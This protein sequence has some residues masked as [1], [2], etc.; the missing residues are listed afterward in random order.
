[1]DWGFLGGSL[2]G[3]PTVTTWGPGRLDI[4]AQAADG[5][6]WQRSWLGSSWSNWNS[7]GGRI[8]GSPVA[9]S[10]DKDRVD[11]VALRVAQGLYHKAWDGYQWQP[12][13]TGWDNL[14]GVLSW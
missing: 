8:I 10:M 11:G 9:L 3:T 13:T 6:L 14:G 1:T 5:A 12:V 2:V 4:F 7:L